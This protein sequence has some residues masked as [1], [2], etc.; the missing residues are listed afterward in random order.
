MMSM[1]KP[2]ALTGQSYAALTKDEVDEETPPRSRGKCR[3][4]TADM[5]SNRKTPAL[6]GQ[7]L[8]TRQ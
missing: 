1:G 8:T 4:T 7:T 2:P 5:A 3:M 6:T